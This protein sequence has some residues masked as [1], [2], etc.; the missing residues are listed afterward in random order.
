[1][2]AQIGP[3]G[4]WPTAHQELLL[5]A[6]LGRGEDA[7]SAWE[8][9]KRAVNID[10]AD[11]GSYRLL[12][13]VYRN[14]Q[15]LGVQDALMGKLKG[16]HRNTWYKNQLL[17][18]LLGKILTA[19]HGAGLQT[20][21]LKGAALIPL[22]YKDYGLRAMNDTDLLVPPAAAPRAL[23]LLRQLGWTPRYRAPHAWSCTDG[24][25]HEFDLHWHVLA[26][27]CKPGDDDDFWSGSVPLSLN[28]IETRALNP[29]DTLLHVCAHGVKWNSLPPVRWV[30]DAMILFGAAEIDWNR[31]VSQARRRELLL[32]LRE[33]LGYLRQT[34]AAPVPEGIVEEMRRAQISAAERWDYR[35]KT[36][37]PDERDPFLT[38][39]AYLREYSRTVEEAG[40]AEKL[41]RW[42]E[43]L[44]D[45]WKLQHVWQ[46]PFYAVA[47]A[48]RRAWRMLRPSRSITAER[49]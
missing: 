2:I 10:E 32:T 41:A 25:G 35:G 4:C 44:R 47:G 6:A 34:L 49:G 23:E 12:P 3:G 9:W 29:T 18:D 40:P 7:R 39:W 15:Q 36:G 16:V 1:M 19:F 14:L 8:E 38:G 48:A 27:C 31:L 11:W 20:L 21:A 33:A 22:H 42:P 24:A 28:G 37:D 26:E 43:F 17:F 13:L 46:V 45:L 30:A 5:R